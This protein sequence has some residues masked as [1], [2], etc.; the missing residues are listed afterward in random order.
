MLVAWGVAHRSDNAMS[1]WE[2]TFLAQLV[3]RVRA[4]QLEVAKSTAEG[5]VAVLFVTYADFASDIIVAYMLLDNDFTAGCITLGICGFSLCMQALIEYLFGAGWRA[6]ISTL[7]AGGPIVHTYREIKHAPRPPGQ[8]VTNGFLLG[9]VRASEIC[10]EAVPM[11]TFQL[12]T[13][14]GMASDERDFAQYFSIA[15][16]VLAVGFLGAVAERDS[17]L[18]AKSRQCH[19]LFFGYFPSDPFSQ[20]YVFAGLVLF[21]GG[22]Y[23]AKM[24]ALGVLLNATPL[25]CIV[26]IMIEGVLFWVARATYA[27]HWRMVEPGMDG[28]IV[29]IGETVVI[30]LSMLAVPFPTVR[31]PTYAGPHLWMAFLV[32]S[33][34]ANFAVAGVGLH[35]GT[36]NGAL[37]VDGRV[38]WSALSSATLLLTCGGA[39]IWKF[40]VPSFRESFYKR[41]TLQ[42]HVAW[43]WNE[44]T[45]ALVGHGQD[46]V[47]A[48]V[49]L[50]IAPRFLPREQVQ[51][52]LGNWQ[53][54]EESAHPPKWFSEFWKRKARRL[55]RWCFPHGR[56]WET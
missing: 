6:T 56:P 31:I 14:M 17:D 45:T 51:A 25:G 22:C 10:F 48:H 7:C 37:E 1:V 13:F 38:I 11:G 54:W 15:T 29:G 27:G 8:S 49:L 19:P 39:L 16:S 43:Q 34:I 2:R 44:R 23:A 26:Y 42:E 52:W 9:L 35:L 28:V 50:T 5:M 36:L 32:Y 53:H 46:A 55:P 30:Y 24:L 3:P 12:C 33:V 18:E 40:M 47:R 4:L 41:F 21:L 20:M